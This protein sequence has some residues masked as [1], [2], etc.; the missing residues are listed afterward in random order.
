MIYQTP[1]IGEYGEMLRQFL[2]TDLQFLWV[3][4]ERVLFESDIAEFQGDFDHNP[5]D[6]LATSI[7][8]QAEDPD[9]NWW[10]GLESPEVVSWHD[11]AVAALLAILRINRHAAEAILLGLS[12]G[13]KGHP[14]ALIPTLV[15][16]AG[17]KIEDIGGSGSFTPLERKGRWYDKRT[18]H[19]QGP[20]EHVP[21]MLHFPV[22]L[23]QCP[24]AKARIRASARKARPKMLYAAPTG[25]PAAAL[26]S[27]VLGAFLNA[28]ADCLLLQYDEAD[29]QVP[30]TVRVIRDKGFKFPLAIRH[31]H[32]DAVKEYDFIF[33]WDDDLGIEN[34]D[35]LRFARIMEI[36]RLDMAQPAIQSPHGLS[37]AITRH[38]PAPPPWRG[39]DG[40]TARSVVGRLTNFVEIMAPVFTR[41]GWR[42]FYGYLD[43]ENLSGWGYDYVPMGR[44]GIVDA[45]PVVHTR[46]VQS[47][48]AKSEQEIRRFLDNQ[49]LFRH[50]PVEQGWLFG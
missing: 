11:R 24:F 43:A 14:E 50:A 49:G 30:G 7:R 21:G 47:I 4:D 13:W 41:K 18:W 22:L 5:A 12:Q 34:F 6:L 9:W 19:W 26:L 33:Y 15:N 44:K 32:P 27:D 37:H 25:A 42:E 29:L 8:T 3:I 46:A 35:P 1:S 38:R 45:L 36:N 28:G 40:R 2:A 10:P 17:L 48:N 20:V 23:Q 39:P 31:L 16:C